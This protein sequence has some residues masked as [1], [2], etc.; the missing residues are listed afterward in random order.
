MYVYAC[1]DVED[2]VHPDSDDIPLAIAGMLSAEGIVASM[3]VV[4]EKARLWERRGRN[5]VIAAVR[6]HDVSLHTNGH[7]VHPVVAEY[8]AEKGWAD[9]VAEAV[10]QEEPGV[11]T[12]T[13]LFGRMPS[14]WATPGSSWAPQIPAATRQLGIP[15]NVYSHAR[16]G[17]TNACWY[18]GQLCYSDYASLPRGEDDLC[19]DAAFEQ[20]LPALLARISEAAA[21]GAACLGLFVGHPTR[22]RYTV[23][24]D[25]LNYKHG[26]NT[27]PEAYQFAPRRSDEDYATGLRNV[28]RL[29]LAVRELPGIEV[30]PVGAIT[31][32]FAPAEKDVAVAELARLAM[33][34]VETGEIPSAD[35]IASP[36][37]LLDALARAVVTLADGGMLPAYLPL[38]AVLGPV[39]QPPALAEPLTVPAE[40]GLERLRGLVRRIGT[41]G[42]LPASVA[43][44][45]ALVGPGPLLR[46]LARAFLDLRRGREPYLVT[47]APGAEEPA[48]AAGLAESIH[49]HLPNWPPHPPDLR[50]DLLALHARLQSWSQKPAVLKS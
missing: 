23:F 49:R 27:D 20:A 19:D 16:S 18:A 36:A 3:C 25:V 13:R 22:L 30:A 35:P 50:L 14:A 5:D 47:L 31:E 32:R 38:R 45:D 29:L 1:F 33:E 7:S 6:R 41:T 24:W 44:R 42:H 12:L 46:T 26:H 40:L 9:G 39:R 43:V 37:Q 11:R 28:R 15:A 21:C 2:L 17:Q 8:L 34:I 10:R 48:G 4:G